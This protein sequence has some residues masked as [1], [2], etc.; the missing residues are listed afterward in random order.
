V[1]RKFLNSILM[2]MQE[3]KECNANCHAAVRNAIKVY[4]SKIEDIHNSPIYLAAWDG[5]SEILQFL[6]RHGAD[7]NWRNE[8]GWT[9]IHWAAQGG[10]TDTVEWLAQHG[11]DINCRTESGDTPIHWA[12]REGHTDAVK[13]LKQHGADVNATN[14]KGETPAAAARWW[15]DDEGESDCSEI[16]TYLEGLMLEQSKQ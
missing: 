1:F 3:W 15:Y 2:N 12:A 13:C 11:A 5:N 7:I 10:R 14:N 9:P 8:Y 16:A 6:V 4:E